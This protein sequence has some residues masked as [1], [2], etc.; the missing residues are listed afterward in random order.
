MGLDGSTFMD[1]VVRRQG[2]TD[3]T[4]MELAL[5]FINERKLAND[6]VAYLES[7]AGDENAEAALR[8]NDG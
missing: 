3:E 6:F 4:V 2:W 7:I 8:E 1:S 5:G